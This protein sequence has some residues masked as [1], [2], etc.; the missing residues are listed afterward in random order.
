MYMYMKTTVNMTLDVELI[1][2]LKEQHINISGLVGELL[3]KASENDA[4]LSRIAHLE[5]EIRDIRLKNKE[6]DDKD[7]GWIS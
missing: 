7:K 3:Q 2:K 4:F 6:K 1:L 5:K